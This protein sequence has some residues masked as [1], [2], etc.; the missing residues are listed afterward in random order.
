MVT[1]QTDYVAGVPRGNGL[2]GKV[3]VIVKHQ[4]TL[5]RNLIPAI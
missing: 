5:Y 1:F 3:S 4:Y 2:K